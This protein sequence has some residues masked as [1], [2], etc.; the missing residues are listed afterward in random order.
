MYMRKISLQGH[1]F[2][3]SNFRNKKQLKK[4]AFIKNSITFE[5]FKIDIFEMQITVEH[6]IS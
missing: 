5:V 6:K 4:S 3:I 1:I 2:S